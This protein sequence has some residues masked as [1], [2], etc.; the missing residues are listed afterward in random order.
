MV[1]VVLFAW[2]IIPL[3]SRDEPKLP[4]SMRGTQGSEAYGGHP[5]KF[6][7]SCF[8]TSFLALWVVTVTLGT[9]LGTVLGTVEPVAAQLPP[10]PVPD[11]NPITESKRVLGKILFWDEQLSSDDSI[12]CGTCHIP[13]AGG[14]DPRQALHPGSDGQFATADDVVGS[15]GVVRRDENGVAID[16]PTFGFEAQVTGRAAPNFFGA[17]WASDLFWDGRAD[18]TF[19]DPVGG[20]VV[21]PSG[22]GLESQALGPVLSSVEMAHDN[23]D[24]DQVIDKLGLVAPL[25]LADDKPAD[26]AAAIQVSPTYAALFTAAFGDAAITPVRI[27]FAIATYERTLV[28][29]ETPWDRF[30][31]GDNGAL[32]RD[33]RNGW[34]AF[35]GNN[36][37]CSNCHTPPLFTNNQFHNVGLRPADEDEGR[38]A[39]T[40]VAGD[41]G[42]MKTPSLRNV[43]LRVS[44][45][46]TGTITDVADAL[47]FYTR[48]G[49]RHF[50]DNQ[51]TIPGNGGDY[52]DINIQGGARADI[53]DFLVNGLTDPRVVAEEFPFDR[54]TLSSEIGLAVQRC[55]D[56]PQQG[57]RVTTDP[58][59]PRLK[60]YG[61]DTGQRTKLIWTWKRGEATDFADFGD[62]TATDGYALCFYDGDAANDGVLFF[63]ARAPASATDWSRIG[64]DTNPK[65]FK[66]SDREFA[67]DGIKKI[68]AKAGIDGKAVIV[69][70]AQGTELATAPLGFPELPSEL[71]LV[72]Q[73]Q[74]GSGQ[75]WE[76]SFTTATRNEGDRLFAR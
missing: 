39:V 69:V 47:D 8:K 33:Q 9:I 27:A 30:M 10:V 2:E 21:I 54:P 3:L 31:A 34:N 20:G 58:G 24:W 53:A 35:N 63:E 73:M 66:Y 43:G 16:D 65:G 70:K 26:V 25:R 67:P 68:K 75:C 7:T 11:E 44:L 18:S 74:S 55:A 29:N 12:A 22:G 72:V 41:F 59:R 49:H 45:M 52:N 71:P 62:P 15:P 56:L 4:R 64:S 23:R 40:G 61:G 57:C 42:D 19:T 50:T 38:R 17:L 48:R 46:H 32:T 76:A 5:V 37:P 1:D 14:A 13:A 51:D 28:A 60:L 6:A 36:T